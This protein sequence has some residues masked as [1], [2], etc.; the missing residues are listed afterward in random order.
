[1]TA[2]RVLLNLALAIALAVICPIRCQASE[3]VANPPSVESS[4]CS[5]CPRH[6][7]EAPVAPDGDDCCDGD[8]ICDGAVDSPRVAAVDL[9]S[10]VPDDTLISSAAEIAGRL[11]GLD[12]APDAPPDAP[13][14]A[15]LRVWL[16]SWLI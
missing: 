1:M 7:A 16:A 13:D 3:I 9:P 10:I 11:V 2:L 6:A 5:C 14:G 4:G 15:T 8:C 12:S